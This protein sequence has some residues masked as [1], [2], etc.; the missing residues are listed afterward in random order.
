MTKAN[1]PQ[2]AI[3][4][5]KPG[6]ELRLIRGIYYLYEYKTV[7]D[8]QRKGPKK[9]SGK[10]L[11]RITESGFIP[12]GKR[13][14]E[15]ASSPANIQKPWCKE[16]G[17]SLLVSQVFVKYI[18][19][20]QQFFPNHWKQILAIAYCRFIYRCPLK[21]IPFRLDQSYLHAFSRLEVKQRL[22]TGSELLDAVSK[23]FIVLIMC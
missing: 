9:V 2:W 18:R 19:A 8:K 11:G 15:K 12:S 13:A 5:K 4:Q 17:V 20:L 1:H 22:V 14:L 21:N 10:L 16:Y 3:D 6:T 7:Y 23:I